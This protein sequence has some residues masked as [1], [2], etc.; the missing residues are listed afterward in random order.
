MNECRQ[1]E[2]NQVAFHIVFVIQLPQFPGG[3]FAGFQVH[4][5]VLAEE[6][7]TL[8]QDKMSTLERLNYLGL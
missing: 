3:C 7:F 2:L 1:A 6:G 5:I 8:N 4:L